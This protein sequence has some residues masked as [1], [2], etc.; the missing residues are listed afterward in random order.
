[1]QYY[2]KLGTSLEPRIG[3]K[4]ITSENLR[5][6]LAAGNYSQNILST[7]SD[8]DIVSLFNGTISSPEDIKDNDGSDLTQKFQKSKHLI[9]GIELDLNENIDLQIEG[10]IKDFSQLTNINRNRIDVSDPEF[11]IESGIAKGID[12]LFKYKRIIFIYGQCTLTGPLQ[13]NLMNLYIVQTLIGDTI[14]IL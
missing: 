12:L 13:E 10:Y 8:R 3:L 5:L 4:Y 14:L 1:M 2:G 9:I 7:S 6:K 11:I